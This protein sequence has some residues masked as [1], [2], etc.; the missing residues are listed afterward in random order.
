[1]TLQQRR[2]ALSE[3]RKKLLGE[4]LSSTS[5]LR[6]I[7]K[8]AIISPTLKEA[9]EATAEALENKDFD[10]ALKLSS[11]KSLI[12]SR[13]DPNDTTDAFQ[14]D[15]DANEK[16]FKTTAYSILE[17]INFNLSMYLDVIPEGMDI[18]S[19][20]ANGE[21]HLHRAATAQGDH[22]IIQRIASEKEA[23]R[24]WAALA[25]E[26]PIQPQRKIQYE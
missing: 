1:M 2:R 19:Q 13:I 14:E 17:T 23:C 15:A 25:F 20:H 7:A 18:I 6:K 10:L 21:L 8:N 5:L 26:N 3:Q 16:F 24:K 4:A 12:C 9:V 22:P 11:C